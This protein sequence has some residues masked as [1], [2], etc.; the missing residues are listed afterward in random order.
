MPEA[1]PMLIVVMKEGASVKQI[2]GV[3]H[4]IESQGL[5]PF[6]SK[7]KD[8]TQVGCMIKGDPHQIEE[9]LLVLDGVE[10]TFASSRPFRL[11]SRE[12]H[13]EN[14]IVHVAGIPVGGERLI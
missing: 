10:R 8:I 3:L 5:T 13:P 4:K 11:A 14:S 9:Q 1:S 12:F 6:L 7:G 2:G